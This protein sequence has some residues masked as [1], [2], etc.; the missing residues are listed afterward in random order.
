MM[1]A[2]WL[3]DETRQWFQR[4]VKDLRAAEICSD[5]LPAE[6]L[7]HCQQAAEKFL[8]A[9]LTWHRTTFRKT[10]ELR[11]LAMVCVGID[12][13]LEATLEPAVVLSQYA[14]KFRYP[15]APYEPDA[16]EAM[17][18]RALAELVRAEIQGRLA[19]LRG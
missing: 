12:A 6:A 4:G 16:D 18:G 5:E 3:R 14:W 15:G 10:H 2:D 9:F 13:T 1:P 17:R 19:V 7:Y 11:E 8:K